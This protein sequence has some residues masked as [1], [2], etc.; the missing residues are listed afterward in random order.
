M[1][2]SKRIAG[3]LCALFVFA[4]VAVAARDWLV[5]VQIENTA[6]NTELAYTN[7][8]SGNLDGVAIAWPSPEAGGNA[9][10]VSIVD[11][12]GKY[13]N[14]L[15]AAD[16]TPLVSVVWMA[17]S[18]GAVR[19]MAGDVLIVTQTAADECRVSINRSK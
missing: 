16:A 7:D 18:Y 9:V 15:V 4:A 13:T 1:K 5:P 11:A 19:F 6:G 14:E 2:N 12:S 3:A 10:A 17:D 8:V